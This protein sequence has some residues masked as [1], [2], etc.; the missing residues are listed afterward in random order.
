MPMSPNA[1]AAAD[2]AQSMQVHMHE[3]LVLG[4]LVVA[5]IGIDLFL[6]LRKPHE[7]TIKECTRWLVFYVSLAGLFG[8][9]TLFRHSSEFA[10]EYF[11]TYFTEYSLSIDNIFIF[12]IIIGSFRVPRKYQQKVL[13]WGIVT[14]LILR[15][16]FILLGATLLESFSWLFFIFAAFLLWTAW[17]QLREGV[18]D[19]KDPDHDDDV[20]KPNAVVRG[21]R[22]VFMVTDGFVGDKMLVRQSHKTFVTP[23]FLCIVSIGSADLMFALDSIPASFGL[24]A[25]PFIIFAA[26]AFALMG[27][28]Q[29][30]F[31]VEGLLERLVYLHYGLAA[32]LA[33]I[34]FKLLVEASHGQGWL[35]FIPDIHPL[36][37]LAVILAILFLTI[38]TSLGKTKRDAIEGTNVEE[39]GDEIEAGRVA[40][41]FRQSQA[42]RER[43]AEPSGAQKSADRRPEESQRPEE[44]RRSGEERQPGNARR[45]GDGSLSGRKGPL[46]GKKKPR[47]RG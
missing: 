34:G 14:A 7:P 39:A 16:V 43:G 45:S 31:L 30:F 25:Q 44:S 46:K 35:E 17:S 37:S 26:N 11:A 28:R 27:L 36:V 1:L 13:L 32:I 2:A 33:F 41:A 40:Q 6:H 24:T 15:L 23:F 19:R 10:F 4:G 18:E 8:V 21:A 20:Y 42:F 12:I 29:L 5:L 22:K 3:W 47:K 38:V 9:Y